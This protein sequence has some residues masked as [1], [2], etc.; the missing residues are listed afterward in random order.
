MPARRDAQRP[1]A[2]RST[3]ARPTDEQ[4]LNAARSAFAEHGF[5]GAS[6]DGIADR[7]DTTKPTLYAHYGSKEGLYKAVI[8]REV[9]IVEQF[10]FAV[11]DAALGATARFQIE[12][13]FAGLIDYARG[14]P[15]GAHLLFG[16]RGPGNAEALLTL[17]SELGA[18]VA[19]NIETFLIEHGRKPTAVVA[20]A[21][22]TMVWAAITAVQDADLD[23]E[24]DCRRRIEVAVT[25]SRSGL[26][27]LG[28][29]LAD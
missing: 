9:G 16:A 5:R 3:A 23:D 20:T 28:D 15:E 19:S 12:T 4:L 10:L 8:D 27:G 18:R 17:A 14:H 22:K 29:L 1:K 7:A 26:N 24:E 6:M 11:Y 21:A 25:F 2:R 13:G